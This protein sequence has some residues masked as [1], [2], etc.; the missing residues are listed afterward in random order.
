MIY[1]IPS[2]SVRLFRVS[3]K[4]RHKILFALGRS[5]AVEQLAKR[6]SLQATIPGEKKRGTGL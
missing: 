5:V 4:V 3:K 1:S 6:K 2:S